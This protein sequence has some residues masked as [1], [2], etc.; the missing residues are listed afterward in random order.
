M[1]QL[2]T[3]L[4]VRNDSLANW[5]AHK[6]VVLLRGEMGIAFDTDGKTYIKIGDGTKTWD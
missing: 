4:V 3:R 2:N 5:E 1:A 6:D